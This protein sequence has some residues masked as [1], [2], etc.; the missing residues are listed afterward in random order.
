M[1]DCRGVGESRVYSKRAKKSPSADF[2][3]KSGIADR[4]MRIK[5]KIKTHQYLN[6]KQFYPKYTK[7]NKIV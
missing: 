3:P 4:R 1:P 5:I 7:N 6:L 2:V